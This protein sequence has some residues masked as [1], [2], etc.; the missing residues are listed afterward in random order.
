M[1]KIVSDFACSSVRLGAWNNRRPRCMSQFRLARKGNGPT[2]TSHHEYGYDHGELGVYRALLADASTGSRVGSFVPNWS[3]KHAAAAVRN[4]FDHANRTARI[5][6]GNL[7]ELV[8][9]DGE[10][11][12]AA[13]DFLVRNPAS[14]IKILHEESIDTQ[15]KFIALAQEDGFEN[16]IASARVPGEVKSAYPWHFAVF[17]TTSFRYEPDKSSFEALV[18]FQDPTFA[19]TLVEAFERIWI[20]AIPPAAL[21]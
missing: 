17:D 20:R 8:Y 14:V 9:G 7:N 12:A 6:T 10:V 21:N 19:K 2:S 11:V 15:H 3:V 13:R 16:R 5:L 18:N 4:L 1:T